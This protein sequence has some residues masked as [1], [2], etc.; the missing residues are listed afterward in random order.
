MRTMP[1]SPAAVTPSGHQPNEQHRWWRGALL[2]ALVVALPPLGVVLML[3][4]RWHRL[5]KLLAIVWA[6]TV[7]LSLLLSAGSTPPSTPASPT[8]ES[9]QSGQ[10]LAAL[11]PAPVPMPTRRPLFGVRPATT[12][13][14]SPAAEDQAQAVDLLGA[15]L[16]QREAGELG[17][18]LELGRQALA[19]WP[20]YEDAR[21]VVQDIAPQATAQ[22]RDARAQATAV[23]RLAVIQATAAAQQAQQRDVQH[24]LQTFRDRTTAAG[25]D[26]RW[27]ARVQVDPERDENLIVMVQNLWH[28]QP[29]QMR[30][31]AAQN[32]WQIWAML[33]SP[34]NLD[35]ARIK[36]TDLNG[37]GVGGSGWLAGSLVD[38]KK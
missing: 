13:T 15:A 29:Y 37:N 19:L 23:A 5:L 32:L 33:R 31:Q 38:V 7:M 30:L 18:A 34:S 22:A 2:V 6:S 3:C 21:R 4:T 9:V 11:P 20:G 26:A 28:L 17:L 16:Y 10:E 1:S 35:R 14:P 8:G 24:A 36:I 25:L 12:V 27:I